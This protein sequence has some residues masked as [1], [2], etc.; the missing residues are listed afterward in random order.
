MRGRDS[1]PRYHQASLGFSK[2]YS[3]LESNNS[4]SSLTLHV[5]LTI[6][7]T[8]MA[9]LW[10]HP[11]SQ[12]W[13]ACFTDYVGKQRK[14]S[15]K[16][17]DRNDA[18]NL[19]V[20]WERAYHRV[21]SETQARH[22]LSDIYRDITR[23]DLNFYTVRTFFESWLKRKKSENSR[24]TYLRYRSIANSF[25][26]FL[27]DLADQDLS[28]ITTDEITGYRDSVAARLST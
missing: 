25:L 13:Y 2:T 28:S 26:T 6:I 16:L 23:R 3:L 14:R 15:T 1:N 20:K 9:S 11:K 22:V 17:T 27:G 4:A 8:I 18:L 10:K 12:Y 7:L 19:A 21:R 24:A 5:I